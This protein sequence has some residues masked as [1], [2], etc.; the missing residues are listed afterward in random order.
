MNIFLFHRLVVT[1]S[2][3]YSNLCSLKMCSFF[4]RVVSTFITSSYST[5]HHL[6]TYTGHLKNLF[7]FNFLNI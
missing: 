3:V 1:Q 4:L 6:R 5:N 2:V 7:P